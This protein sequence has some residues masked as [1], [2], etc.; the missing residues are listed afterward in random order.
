MSVSRYLRLAR[1]D[2]VGFARR[3]REEAEAEAT[4]FKRRVGQE[5][6]DAVR[7]AVGRSGAARLVARG[8]LAEASYFAILD[9]CTLNLHARLPKDVGGDSAEIA[10]TL[11]NRELRAPAIV[12]RD[13]LGQA[14]VSA[15][16]LLG[17]ELGGVHVG[18]GSWRVA[19]VLRSDGAERL[20][21]LRGRLRT[22]DSGDGP[23][24]TDPSCARTGTRFTPKVSSSGLCL[25]SVTP[26]AP[27]AEVT[28][29][30]VKASGIE[31]EGRLVGLG[32][33]PGVIVRF[34]TGGGAA[35]QTIAA[36]DGTVFRARIPLAEM[37]PDGASKERVWDVFA[38]VE[39][40]GPLRVGRH[41]H[42][43]RDPRRTLRL[44]Q[45]AVAP[46]IGG[47]VRVRPY[48]TG[49]GDLSVACAH[50]DTFS[51]ATR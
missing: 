50:I 32:P 44:P 23:T 4:R 30:K 40:H 48:Y 19:V 10:F 9:G 12:T 45:R 22:A 17:A 47:L 36:T 35:H 51:G 49:A 41:L 37:A 2:P 13:V 25:I 3:V 42:D 29:L 1:T 15:A 27:S 46:P 26:P 5:S 21:R 38:D 14:S 20:V 6:R 33:V 31:I 7:T 34:K 24:I 11:R 18:E 43:L 39:G 28:R 8:P 16:V